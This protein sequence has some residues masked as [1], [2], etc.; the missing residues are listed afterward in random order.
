MWPQFASIFLS[1]MKDPACVCCCEEASCLFLSVS[2]CLAL[3][4]VSASIQVRLSASLSTSRLSAFL[5]LFL[6]VHICAGL[7]VPFCFFLVCASIVSL[8]ICVSVC[9][10]ETVCVS[11]C[12]FACFSLCADFCRSVLTRYSPTKEI[13]VSSLAHSVNAP[14]C[15]HVSA[16]GQRFSPTWRVEQ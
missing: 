13:K 3:Y 12:D 8:Y 9:V 14:V 16:I 10:S 11:L 15:H 1:I 7:S 2:T 5:Y 4:A 6:T